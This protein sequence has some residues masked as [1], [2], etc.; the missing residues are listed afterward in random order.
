MQTAHRQFGAEP[1]HDRTRPVGRIVVHDDDFTVQRML[2]EDVVQRAE[3]PLDAAGFIIG[4][5]DD[6]KLQSHV[7][8]SIYDTGR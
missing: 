4:G 3:E 7:D 5:D 6:R 2:R 8:P 1:V